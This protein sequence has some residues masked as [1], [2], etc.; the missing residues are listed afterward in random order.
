[1]KRSLLKKE[2][3]AARR[4]RQ[5]HKSRFRKLVIG[6]LAFQF[7]IGKDFTDIRHPN[8]QEK[9]LVSHWAMNKMT[10][11][12]YEAVPLDIVVTG[13][14]C[15]TCD[16]GGS[17]AA[18]ALCITPSKIREFVLAHSA[19]AQKAVTRATA[20]QAAAKLAKMPRRRSRG[21]L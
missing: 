19:E 16:C 7:F 9:Y 8:G 15:M 11:E 2:L 4:E 10:R 1:M 13:C 5:Q 20:A 21:W 6:D 17:H 18:Y 14:F 12:E 3:R